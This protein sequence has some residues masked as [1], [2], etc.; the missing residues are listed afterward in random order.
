MNPWIAWLVGPIGGL[1]FDIGGVV[2]LVIVF[3]PKIAALL[4]M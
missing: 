2:G 4:G 1:V 3:G